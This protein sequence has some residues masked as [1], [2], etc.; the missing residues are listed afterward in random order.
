MDKKR[1]STGSATAL[2]LAFGSATLALGARALAAE[3]D[4]PTFKA[5]YQVE[6][7][8]HKVGREDLSVSYDAVRH[9]YR[10]ESRT[11]ATGLLKLVRHKPSIQRTEFILHDGAIRPLEFW[12]DDGTRK[13]EDDRHI[14]FDWDRSTATVTD[15][16][17]TS[18]LPLQ[19]NV[20]DPGT[21][22]IAIMLDLSHEKTPGPFRYTDGDSPNT[23][24]YT[25]EGKASVDIEAGQFDTAVIEQH[26][27][28]SSR[29]MRLWTAPKL[30]YLPVKIVQY[31]D[32]EL[33]T[34]LTLESVEGFD[35]QAGLAAEK[36]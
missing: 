34:A 25:D 2:I 7:K 11:E 12:L 36:R 23:Y 8:G 26:H 13:G 27:E 4:V 24:R 30:D 1:S 18:M 17:G 21:I 15:N 31:K 9:H 29:H 35:G 20:L 16:K 22:L 14:V 3:P 19:P 10:F 5:H 32:D 28:G 6:Y 33:L